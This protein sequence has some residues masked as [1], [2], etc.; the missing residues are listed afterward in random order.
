MLAVSNFLL[1]FVGGY[2]V[3]LDFLQA[4]QKQMSTPNPAITNH[5]IKVFAELL[6][7]K[8]GFQKY[9]LLTFTKID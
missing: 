9:F 8:I 6:F 1:L 5:S 7:R 3:F 4:I 2:Q